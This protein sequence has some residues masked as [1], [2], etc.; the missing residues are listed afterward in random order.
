MFKYNLHKTAIVDIKEKNIF[1]SIKGKKE[2]Y[3]SR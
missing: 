3:V 1:E 2:N